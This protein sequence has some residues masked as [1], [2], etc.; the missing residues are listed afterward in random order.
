MTT[1]PAWSSQLVDFLRLLAPGDLTVF[2]NSGRTQTLLSGVVV[3]PA[4]DVFLS[5]RLLGNLDES[6]GG[7]SAL[8]LCAAVALRYR[9]PAADQMCDW[10]D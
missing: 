9:W 10:N 1:S 4:E 3:S 7:A 5:H 6:F 8:W 2:E